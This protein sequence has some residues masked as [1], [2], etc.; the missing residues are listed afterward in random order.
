MR[1]APGVPVLV[2]GPTINGGEQAIGQRATVSHWIRRGQPLAPSGWTA[3]GDGWVVNLDRRVLWMSDYG[4]TTGIFPASSL[5]PLDGQ[6]E[7]ESITTTAPD[8]AHA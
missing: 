6:A 8:V 5:M 7:P 2:I 4:S 3:V 1:I